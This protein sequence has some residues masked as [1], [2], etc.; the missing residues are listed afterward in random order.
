V[1]TGWGRTGESF[2]GYEA[3]G[4][5]PDLLTF[6]KG[7]GNGLAMAGVIARGEIMDSITANSISTFGGNP[8]VTA[9]SLANLRFL[10]DHDLQ[11]NAAAMGHRILERLRPAE[12]KHAVVGEVR[13]KG[14]MIGIELVGPDGR[15]PNPAAASRALEHA[16]REGL[17]VG[18][19][20][21]YGNCLRLAPPLSLTAEEADT[22]T[23]VLLEVLAI[24]DQEE[25]GDRE[26][27]P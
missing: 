8:L 5:R 18:K 11:A 26:G 1:Q 10:L 12:E 7:L 25:S 23:A 16:R 24:V 20:G 17:L 14:L 4:V 19:G 27:T 22:G 2:W 9:G 13:G 21:L 6:A 3:Q 15:T